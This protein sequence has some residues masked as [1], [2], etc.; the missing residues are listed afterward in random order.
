MEARV[1]SRESHCM[2]CLRNTSFSLDCFRCQNSHWLQEG[3]SSG[4]IGKQRWWKWR[5]KMF[6]YWPLVLPIQKKKRT[7][8][9]ERQRRTEKDKEAERMFRRGGNMSYCIAARGWTECFALTW[10][11]PPTWGDWVRKCCGHR[12]AAPRCHWETHAERDLCRKRAISLNKEH[13]GKIQWRIYIL[14]GSIKGCWREF[15]EFMTRKVMKNYAEWAGSKTHC[16]I[17]LVPYN[18]NSISSTLV[19]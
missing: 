4:C 10:Q 9:Q 5:W 19:V 6:W 7:K 1:L 14:G 16:S 2:P 13:S 3:V 15:I 12:Q 17:D 8:T 18:G 11:L